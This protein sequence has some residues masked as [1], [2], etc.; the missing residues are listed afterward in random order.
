MNILKEFNILVPSYFPS[1]VFM[2]SNIN[3]CKFPHPNKHHQIIS[4][5]M[6]YLCISLNNDYGNCLERNKMKEGIKR[7]KMT[8]K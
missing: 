2:K 1:S 8:I 6:Q 7:M 4:E 3:T 5:N